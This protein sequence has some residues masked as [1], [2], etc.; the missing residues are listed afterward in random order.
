MAAIFRSPRMRK[1]PVTGEMVQVLDHE[2]KPEFHQRWRAR[3]VDHRGNRKTYTLSKNKQHSQAQADR[4]EDGINAILAHL[5]HPEASGRESIPSA[6]RNA[7]TGAK[8]RGIE[9]L[10]PSKPAPAGKKSS[11]KRSA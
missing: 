7:A 8:G 5:G 3:I 6:P 11:A 2:G 4:I 1:D 10:I 9:A